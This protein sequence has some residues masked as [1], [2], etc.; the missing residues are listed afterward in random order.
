M[1]ADGNRNLHSPRSL[2]TAEGTALPEQEC[3][4]LDETVRLIG[5]A[6]EIHRSGCVN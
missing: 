2:S 5:S 6:E 4:M 1:M 3:R